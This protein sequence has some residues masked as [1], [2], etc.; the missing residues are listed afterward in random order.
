MSK[1]R[2]RSSSSRSS[3]KKRSSKKKSGIQSF[4]ETS[5]GI[6]IALVAMAF[7]GWWFFIRTPPEE[8]SPTVDIIAE[9]VGIDASVV[10]FDEARDNGTLEEQQRWLT[11]LKERPAQKDT[12]LLL[13]SLSRKLEM[14][15]AILKRDDLDEATRVETAEIALESMG[16]IFWISSTE[17]L[18]SSSEIYNQYLGV[19]K[20]FQG[21]SNPEIQKEAKIAEAKAVSYTHLTLPTI[22][23]V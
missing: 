9:T 7:A 19:S 6:G 12:P 5:M 23:S 4:V 1:K 2:R 3:S 16:E 22:Y 8:I 14:A 21:D 15:Q 20:Q 17:G 11:Q 10:N 13:S 18:D